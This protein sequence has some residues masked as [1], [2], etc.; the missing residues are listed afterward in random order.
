MNFIL[1]FN[2]LIEKILQRIKKSRNEINDEHNIIKK[3]QVF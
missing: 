3:I 1:I 2:C